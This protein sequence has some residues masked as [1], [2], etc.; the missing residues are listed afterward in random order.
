MGGTNIRGLMGPEVIAGPTKDGE[1]LTHMQLD[2]EP[3][4]QA[5][6]GGDGNQPVMVR[7]P[8]DILIKSII[9][10]TQTHLAYTN[11]A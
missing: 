1:G 2:G 7:R 3:W 4:P 10:G 9:C 5:I 8:T 11:G 6:P